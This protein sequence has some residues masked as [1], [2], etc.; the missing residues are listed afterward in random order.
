MDGKNPYYD[1][2]YDGEIWYYTGEMVNARTG[3]PVD[4]NS[5]EC[6]TNTVRG[7]PAAGNPDGW[8][9][10]APNDLSSVKAV[11]LQVTNAMGPMTT[12]TNGL[13]HLITEQ[14]I[15]PD[16][17]LGQ[18]IWTWTSKLSEGAYSWE[19][20]PAVQ[21]AQH[22]TTPEN[23]TAAQVYPGIAT[24]GLRYSYASVGRD[25]LRVVG[26]IPTISKHVLQREYG[27]GTAADF[28]IDAGLETILAQ[29]PTADVVVSDV[30]PVGMEYIAGS[31]ETEPVITGTPVS[32]QKLT[33]TYRD[34]QPNEA[35]QVITFK[36]LVP[37][38]AGARLRIQEH[39]LCG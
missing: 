2:S 19:L 23:P 27:P 29:P 16:A 33:W 13:V 24:P 11:K 8:S 9:T 10:A 37:D 1:D 31:A 15:K 6:G 28:R 26:S 38:S 30:L 12:V 7:N 35:P 3:E 14:R 34:M 32:G 5:F 22:R 25:V 4:P 20:T 21:A 17:P 39:G 36:A 18:D